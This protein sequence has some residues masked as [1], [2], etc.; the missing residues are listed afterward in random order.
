MWPV[1]SF[2]NM[3]KNYFNCINKT[4][5]NPFNKNLRSEKTQMTYAL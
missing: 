1:A 3:N 2:Q 5:T 4:K